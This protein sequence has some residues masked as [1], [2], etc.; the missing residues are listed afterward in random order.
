MKRNAPSN[1]DL[2]DFGSTTRVIFIV[3]IGSILLQT[4]ALAHDFGV[5]KD[6]YE[7]FLSGNQ[8]VLADIP[9]LLGSIAAG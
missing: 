5:G 8:A 2:R 4:P 1:Q 7:D 3:G 6:A 9:V